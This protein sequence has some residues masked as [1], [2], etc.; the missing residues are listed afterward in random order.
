VLQFQYRYPFSF[1]TIAS[2][3]ITKFNYEPRTNLTSATGVQQLDEDRFVF[4]RRVDT[5]FS[6]DISYERVIVDR[7]NGGQLTN[8]LI[9][10]RQGGERL[11]ERGVIHA[12]DGTALHNHF[13]FDHQGIK[14]FKVEA[15]KKGV[16]RVLKTIKFAEFEK[17][18]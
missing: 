14:T 1:Q 8:E 3:F 17:S 6:D 12:E 18:E 15:F 16:E 4:Y 7:R 13:V 2:A 11:F 9:K 5:V 10:P